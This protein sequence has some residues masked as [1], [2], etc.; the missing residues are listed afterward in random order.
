[1]RGWNASA[2][3][4]YLAKST[5]TNFSTNSSAPQVVDIIVGATR[6][7]DFNPESVTVTPGTI[8]RFDFS[9]TNHTFMQSSFEYPCV[10]SSE[11][12]AGFNQLNPTNVSGE[13]VVDFVVQS[14]ASQWFFCAQSFPISHCDAGLLFSLNP[15]KSSSEI[16]GNTKLS[17][18]ATHPM[19]TAMVQCSTDSGEN[20]TSSAASQLSNSPTRPTTILPSQISSG[21]TRR[22]LGMIYLM[23]IF[24]VVFGCI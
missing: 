16:D 18:T 9:G 5:A 1:M 12:N 7:L 17:S 23:V 11:L 6:E 19:T 14:N 13:Y 22:K 21:G 10:N 2:T 4:P 20:T 8:L 15:D 3:E 24:P